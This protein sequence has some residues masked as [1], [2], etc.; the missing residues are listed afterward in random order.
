MR[1]GHALLAV[2]LAMA[3]WGC[4]S[5][6]A[7]DVDAARTSVDQA[8]VAGA[9]QYAPESFKAAQDAWVAL[10][11]ELE[12]Q[13]AKW[14]K[15]YEEATRLAVAAKAAGDKAVSEAAEAKRQADA[16]ALEA[17]RRADARTAA[18]AAAKAN[19]VRV[20]GSVK[21]PVKIKDVQPLYPDIAKSARATGAV[22]I[23]ATID[24]EGNVADARVVRSVPLLD[25]AALNAVEQWKYEPLM[26]DGK[27]V[28]AVMTVTVNFKL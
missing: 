11:A 14:V 2:G 21:P 19:A 6:P 3:V 4:Q 1:V 5:P 16:T 24:T 28:P 23:E 9:S 17:R 15:S 12:A 26:R 27:P 25:Q 20:G 18:R 22:V 10:D 7:A 8:A 13:D